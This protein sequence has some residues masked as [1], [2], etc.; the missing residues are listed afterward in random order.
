M[1]SRMAPANQCADRLVEF[2]AYWLERPELF[3]AIQEG[4]DPE[5]RALRVLKWFIVRAVV[6]RSADQLFMV[7]IGHTQGSIHV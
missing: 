7:R 4:V 2:P 5:G 3:A 6:T 1:A